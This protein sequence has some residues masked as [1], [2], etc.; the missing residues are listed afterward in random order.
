MKGHTFR[1]RRMVGFFSA[2]YPADAPQR[3]HMALPAMCPAAAGVVR[4][5]AS[6]G[7]VNDRRA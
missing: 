6:S 4:P 3:G 1:S 7:F 5:S 2:G